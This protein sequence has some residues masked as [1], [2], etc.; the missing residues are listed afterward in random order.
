MSDFDI[1]KYLTTEY[2]GRNV[3]HIKSTDSTNSLAKRELNSENGTVFIADCQT[4]GRGRNGK[5][6][7]SKNEEGLWFS[8]LLKPDKK[9]KEL[10]NLTLVVGL[11]VVK[12]INKL[13]NVNAMIKWPNDII[14]DDRKLCGVLC[15]SVV[16]NGHCE[17]IVCGIGINILTTCFDEEISKI[18]TSLKI[19][20]KSEYSREE[21]CAIILNEFEVLY[22]DYLE[23]GLKNS[24][25]E[26]CKNCITIG[27][28][29]S[30]VTNKENKKA[31]AIDVNND[32]ELIVVSDGETITVSSGEVSVRGLM[33]YV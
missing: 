9:V 6:W 21:I 10:A 17:C 26:Y 28:E 5:S 13:C 8:I 25:S 33:G 3:V 29:I 20:T 2:I 15:E 30:L 7:I 31:L 12:A 11:A 19:S 1:S 14:L 24:I 22:I 23:N 27:K 4:A 18:A 32:G 16:N